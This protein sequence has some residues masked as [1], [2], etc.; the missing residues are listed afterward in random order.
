MG[1]VWRAETDR[2]LAENV[3]LGSGLGLIVGTVLAFVIWG[4][5]KAAGA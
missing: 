5:A 1:F 4:A 2:R 3:V